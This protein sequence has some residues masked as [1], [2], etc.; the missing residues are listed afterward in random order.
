MANLDDATVGLLAKRAYDVAGCASG[1]QGKPLKVRL[2]T[3]LCIMYTY[4]IWAHGPKIFERRTITSLPSS[5]TPPHMHIHTSHTLALLL[6]HYSTYLSRHHVLTP[7]SYIHIHLSTTRSTSTGRGSSSNP[8]RMY[9]HTLQSRCAFT[10][11]ASSTLLYYLLLRVT[12]Y[13]PQPP[14]LSLLHRCLA[15]PP[16]FSHH[17]PRKPKPNPKH[18]ANT[19]RPLSFLPSPVFIAYEYIMYIKIYNTIP[20]FLPLLVLVNIYNI[21]YATHRNST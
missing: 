12:T 15:Q 19:H 4:V 14:S 16:Y 6:T 20:Y 13:S 2:Q 17:H 9:V 1:F 18:T 7:P 5:N 8:S 10:H 11:A 21:Q 3:P